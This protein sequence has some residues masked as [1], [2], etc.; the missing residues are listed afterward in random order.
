MK[1]DKLISDVKLAIEMATNRQSHL[2]NDNFDVPALASLQIRHLLNNLGALATNYLECGV[3]KGGCFT[4]SISGN[5]NI[6]YATAVDSFESDHMDGETAKPQF[7]A[8]TQKFK[9]ASTK[10]KLIQADCFS[11][12]LNEI[13]EGVDFYLYDAGHSEDDQ[14]KALTYYYTV[15]A[16]EFI[17]CVDDYD[18]PEVKKGTQDGIKEMGLSIEFEQVLV[19]GD[20][21]NDGWWRGYY[22]AILKSK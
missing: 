15:L 19:G 9:P 11:V 7:L 18:L 16:K 6:L 13:K 8:N 1:N 20:H 14:R 4:S 17:L 22:I 12:D 2:A 10:F 3:H 5:G 21:D